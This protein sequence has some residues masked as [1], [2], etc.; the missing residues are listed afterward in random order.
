MGYVGAHSLTFYKQY[1]NFNFYPLEIIHF[2]WWS[3][4][5]GKL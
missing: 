1:F 4:F 5:N 2:K 3:V